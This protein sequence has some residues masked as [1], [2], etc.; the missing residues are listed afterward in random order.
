MLASPAAA[1]VTALGP[2]VTVDGPSADIQALSG[3]AVAR[4][5]TGGLIYLKDVGG[6]PHVFVSRLTSGAFQPPE[7]I[8]ATLPTA[9]SQPVIGA[10]GAGQL[11]VGFIN[12]GQLYTSIASNSTTPFTV[13]AVLFSGA[14]NP[15]LAMNSL[16]NKAYLAFTATGAGG[17]D[18]RCGYYDNGIWTLESTPLDANLADDAGTGT[19]RPDA[20]AAGD[21][22]GIVTWGEAGHVYARRIWGAVPSTAVEQ[23]DL[24]AVQPGWSEVGATAPTVAVGGDSSFVQVIFQET[25]TNG[26]SKQTRVLMRRLHGGAF[27]D[28]TAPDALSTPDVEGADEPGVS[29][30]EYGNGIATVARDTTNQIYATLLGKNGAATSVG[31]LDSLVN[32]SPP[33][34]VPVAAG[35]YSD[36]VAWQHDPGPL[37][38]PEIRARY[39]DGSNYGPEMVLSS[40]TLGPTDAADGLFAAS[41]IQADVAIAW[42]QGTGANTSIVTDQ[43]YHGIGGFKAQ[44]SFQYVRT[45]TPVLS[46][47]SPRARWGPTYTVTLDGTEIAQTPATSVR[48]APLAEGRH[49]WAVTAVNGG[50]LQ[51]SMTPATVFVDTV[52]PTASFTLRGKDRTGK[53]VRMHVTD[54]DVPPG[55][56]PAQASGIK[57]VIARWGDG[58]GAQT[59]GHNTRHTYLKPGLYTVR[60]TVTDRA[61]NAAT[62]K[63]TVRIKKPPPKKK[64]KKKHKH[65]GGV[66]PGTGGAHP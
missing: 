29:M 22:V 64:K 30:A 61:G 21:G 37:G 36:L 34:V 43:L 49:S 50:G 42:V 56:T 18:I 13:P 20:A 32:F 63:Q 46:W 6:I 25:V 53:A 55:G 57:S 28:P 19:D 62:V 31:R 54:T 4:D 40:P 65:G 58:T 66:H 39:Y 7:E 47:T 60:V 17:H 16:D 41:D 3:L 24:P 44:T 1:Q 2:P 23:A 9:S 33:Y 35:Y 52:P 12:A 45:L 48:T 38:V 27:E 11:V 59:I 10:S 5:G 8:D 15:S 26:V 14:S 51:A